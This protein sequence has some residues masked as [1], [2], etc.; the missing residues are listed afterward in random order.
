LAGLRRRR[1]KSL[2]KYRNVEGIKVERETVIILTLVSDFCPSQRNPG[3]PALWRR[4]WKVRPPGVPT[5]RGHT[6]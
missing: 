5:S 4:I 3:G 6:V 1:K 2:P